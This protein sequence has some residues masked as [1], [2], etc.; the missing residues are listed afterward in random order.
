MIVNFV[1]SNSLVYFFIPILKEIWLAAFFRK[2]PVYM[3]YSQ[4]KT[5]VDAIRNC[6]R[7]QE[8]IMG[9]TT[10]TTGSL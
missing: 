8:G 1:F 10:T 4:G 6:P 9:F 5:E 2:Q 7:S 3:I